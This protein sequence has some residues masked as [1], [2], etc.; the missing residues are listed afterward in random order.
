M[1]LRQ[2][3]RAFMEPAPRTHI[4]P[5]RRQASYGGARTDRL[6][7]DWY[8]PISS[9]DYEI[10][11]SARLLRAR[12]RQL[13]RDNAY[14]AGFVDEVANN[15][16]GV[17]GIQ[18]EAAVTTI[19][20]ELH[21]PT[22][23][24]IESSWAD[25]C[26]PENCSAD[27]I[28]DMAQMQRLAIQTVVVDG[29]ALYRKLRYYDNAHGFALASIDADQLDEFYNELPKVP[30]GNE[31]RM[32]VE[33]T[34]YGKPVAYHLWTR[35]PSD[36]G[37]RMR[38]RVPAE[39]II[40]LFI[41]T[42]PRQTRGVTWF[43]PVL[44]SFKMYDGYTEAELVAARTAAAKMGFIVTKTT[45]GVGPSPD[46]AKPSEPRQMEAA[47][48]IIEELDRGKE[49]QEWDPKHPSV[50]FKE[51]SNVILRGVARG[52]GMSYMTFT[53]DL[54]GTS[55]SSGR[56]GLLPERDRW[57]VLQHFMAVR[58]CRVVYRDW[59]T[60][61]RLTGALTVDARLA[62]DLTQITWKGRG[63]AWVDPLKDVQATILGIQHGVDSRTDALAEEGKD[64][65]DTF[66]HLSEEVALAKQYGIDINPVA[67]PVAGK[68]MG[69][70]S[71]TDTEEGDKQDN[72]GDDDEH[73]QAVH[74]A[75]RQL[76]AIR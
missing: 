76:V 36:A 48:G 4:T 56:I 42:R 19:A 12:A 45:D 71:Q 41:R 69:Q 22:N 50:A 67:A 2:R 17:Q 44:A 63:W 29:E 40:H 54:Q 73:P 28:D 62:S 16:I 21:D 59:T 52:L 51:F 53:G 14:A 33:I 32:G 55:Y 72:T 25:F 1:G 10:R 37:M 18:L 46:T 8:A 9:A 58:F 64:L 43:A 27:G 75:L 65:E 39:D 34:Q 60:Y 30:G 26:N 74:S 31:I 5:I 13:V 6:Y 7:Q 24:A 68:G 20:E 70:P 35:H 15:V 3:L 23:D 66:R 57:R 61:A 47:P 11:Q 49:F 38:E